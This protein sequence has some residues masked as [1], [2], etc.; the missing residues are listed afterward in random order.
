ML[1][2]SVGRYLS[3]SSPTPAPEGRASTVA[4]PRYKQREWDRTWMEDEYPWKSQRRHSK[5]TVPMYHDDLCKITERL[6]ISRM[7]GDDGT[8]CGRTLSPWMDSQRS[9]FANLMCTCWDTATMLLPEEA[10]STVEELPDPV[11]ARKESIS[12]TVL[13]RQLTVNSYSTR[14]GIS[15]STA[16]GKSA[17]L[18]KLRTICH[19]HR[20]GTLPYQSYLLTSPSCL[21]ILVK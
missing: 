14:L 16:L 13:N 12:Y 18:Y 20:I 2:H 10:R 9:R 1:T 17:L 21:R 7:V 11:S 6:L 5:D 19:F 8:I 3:R 15:V 4:P